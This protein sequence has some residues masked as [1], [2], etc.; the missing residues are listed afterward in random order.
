LYVGWMLSFVLRGAAAL[1]PSMVSLTERAPPA[2]PHLS[3]GRL[4]MLAAAALTAPAVDLVQNLRGRPVAVPV[5][6]LATMAL[7]LLALARLFELAAG[8]GAQSERQRLLDRVLRAAEE[9]RVRVASELHDGSIQQLAALGHTAERVG[10]RMA[11]G[12]QAGAA[13]L[14]R[15]L[16]EALSDQVDELRRLMSELRPPVLDERG[17]AV[18]LRDHVEA[19]T[20]KHDVASS[21]EIRLSGR[22]DPS[23]ETILY[24][25]AQE[26]LVNVAKHARAGRVSV[27]L[28]ESDD[29]VDLQ[30]RDDGVGFEPDMA[31]RLPWAGHFGLASMRERV[32]LAGGRCDVRSRPG[33][34]TTVRVALPRSHPA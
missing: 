33:H 16:R 34:G 21:V 5:I 1:H 23:V 2:P 12:D 6:S 4:A 31:A 26:S 18:A 10:R 11:A 25:A 7:V 17:L 14:L 22:L 24:R 32:A 27:L 30:V 9:E 8:F 3:R 15:Q 13:T 29:T 28:A 19:F 20:R